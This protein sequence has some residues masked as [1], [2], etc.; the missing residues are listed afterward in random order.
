[1]DGNIQKNKTPIFDMFSEKSLEK[2]KNP[3]PSPTNP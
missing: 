1:M 2:S 3:T